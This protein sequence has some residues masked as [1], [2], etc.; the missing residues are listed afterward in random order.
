MLFNAWAHCWLHNHAD[1]VVASVSAP[2]MRPEVAFARLNPQTSA[3]PEPSAWE[4]LGP[5]Y[6][7]AE[8]PDSIAGLLG[9][10]ACRT[11]QVRT[12]HMCSASPCARM[13]PEAVACCE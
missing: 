8:H 12:P 6:A 11:L 1:Y 13:W 9:N 5:D 10:I 7:D 2:N 4:P 3:G